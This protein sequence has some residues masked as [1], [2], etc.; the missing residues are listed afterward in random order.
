[1]SG[2]P[3]PVEHFPALSALP[4]IGHGFT[5]RVPGLEMSHDKAEALAR[6]DG[7]HRQIR[8]EH[9]LGEMPFVTAQQVHGK[10]IGVV[11]GTVRTDE[12]FQN[13][14]GLIT[15]QR[16]IS[17]GIYVADCCAAYLVDPVRHAIGLVHSGKKGTELGVVPNAIQTMTAQFGARPA[18][19]VVQLSP[20][21]RPPH[22][23]IDFA[24]E[25]VRQCR[26]LGV[27][28][29]HDSGTC[30]ACDLERYYSYRSEKGRTG[31]M[32]AFLA[33]P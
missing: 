13:C 32:L 19:L 27:S 33:F 8:V 1:V 2:V 25:I 28:A 11:D 24:A 18:D 31:R 16:G 21:I 17:L 7:V 26:E 22:Y 29:I 20:C 10:Q 4:G 3:L 14:D 5:L 23:E 15:A 30:T 12:C 6:L 9:Q